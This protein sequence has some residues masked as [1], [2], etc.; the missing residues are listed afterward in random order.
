MKHTKHSLMAFEERVKRAFL[1]KRIHAPVH[2][3]SE[4]QAEP[5]LA[6][7]ERVRPQDW[8]F[9]TWRSHWHALLK[10]VPED[11]LFEMILD[12][13]SMCLMS[14]EHR[15]M[16][17]SIVGGMLPIALGVAQGFQ[18]WELE[19]WKPMT[20]P[21]RNMNFCD[22]PA[23]ERPPQVWVFVGDMCASTGLFQE[24]LR[25]AS[26]RGLPV[27]VMVEDNG[28]ST[29]TPTDEAWGDSLEPARLGSYQYERVGPH[30]GVGE[31][32]EF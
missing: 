24:F 16:A 3:C 22:W 30:V 2:L 28:L 29:D 23:D 1:D 9:S 10:G 25:F 15:F 7:F 32:V 31:H 13:R 8:V 19:K 5:L 6:I 4:G 12:G 21:T 27:N 20:D 14:R 17:G 18:L 26:C 11:E